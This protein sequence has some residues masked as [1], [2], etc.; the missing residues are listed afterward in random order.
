MSAISV[1][2]AVTMFGVSPGGYLNLLDNMLIDNKGDA[3]KVASALAQS[4][5]FKSAGFYPESLSPEQKADKMMQTYG[6]VKTDGSVGATA[7][8]YF[9]DNLKNGVD[10]GLLFN[11][12]NQFLLSNYEPS[13][14]SARM[15]LSNKI[16]VAMYDSVTKANSS[17]DLAV[18]AQPLSKVTATSDVSTISALE[19]LLKP[20]VATLDSSVSNINEGSSLVFTLANATVGTYNIAVAGTGITAA[21]Y[22]APTTVAVGNSGTAAFTVS[23]LADNLTEGAETMNITATLV[24]ATTGLN[25]SVTINDT[26]LT[27]D[28]GTGGSTGTATAK[29]ITV[30]SD[31]VSDASLVNTTN[32]GIYTYTVAVGDVQPAATIANFASG[33]KF[34]FDN[35]LLADISFDAG[36]VG[37]GTMTMLVVSDTSTIE[38]TLTGVPATFDVAGNTVAS[39]NTFFGVGS[40]V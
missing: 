12:A 15:L 5:A 37:D 18:L 21:D 26:S 38:I 1:Q 22:S 33:D 9:V 13:W 25:K 36:T 24:S 31:L 16:A 19:S 27:L 23:A 40:L 11:A 32:N 10:I 7:Y 29:T 2:L 20:V 34:D 28:L 30:T 35:A 8:N 14:A 6:L 39:F 4:P 3:S 17:T